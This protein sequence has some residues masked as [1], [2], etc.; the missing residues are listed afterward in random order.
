MKFGILLTAFLFLTMSSCQ[1]SKAVDFKNSL[2][3]SQ[4]RASEIILGKEGPGE[5]KLKCLE[6]D[7][8]KGA[9]KALELQNKEFNRL[10]AD[11]KKLSTDDIPEGKPLKNAALEYYKSLKD[12][13][14]FDRKEIEQRALLRTVK[15][16]E[17]KNAL[18]NIMALA[19]E[20][21]ILYAAVYEKET[22]LH[23]AVEGFEAANGF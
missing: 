15:N 9:L 19:R 22:L 1:S 12:L 8:Y 11:I 6:K 20:K 16:N 3:E 23:T 18:N 4:R 2:E 5:K 7:D 14:V 17:L 13:H 21:K 10:I